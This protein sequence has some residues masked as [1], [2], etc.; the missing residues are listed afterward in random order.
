MTMAK[1]EGVKSIVNL[2]PRPV[3]VE[4][5]EGETF[6]FQPRGCARVESSSHMVGML[7]LPE[8]CGEARFKVEEERLARF[9]QR[10]PP[11]EEGV[12]YIVSR[13]VASVAGGRRDL[14]VPGAA[15]RDPEG[16]II[17]AKGFCRVV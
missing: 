16:R 17:G 12:Y 15:I 14:L 10:L 2:T 9:V 1:V 4:T 13:L 3:C 7:R 6:T 5:A 8:S 11:E